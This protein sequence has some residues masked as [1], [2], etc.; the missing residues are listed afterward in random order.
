MDPV[1]QQIASF[2]PLPNRS[3][4]TDNYHASELNR[5][6]W[7]SLVFKLD[8]RPTENDAIG[9]RY[10]TRVNSSGSPYSGSDLGLFGSLANSLSTLAGVTYTRV[11]GPTLVNEARAGFVRMSDHEAS[12]YAG[13]DI[14]AQLGLPSITDDPHLVGFPRF[15]VLNLAAIGDSTGMPVDYTVNNYEIA[16]AVSWTRG[17]HLLK[18]GAD[19]LR[20]QF[21]QQLYNN[22]RGSFNFL[23][24]ASGVPF[25]DLL[26]GLPDSTSRQ[27][28]AEPAYLFS[29]DWGLFLQDHLAVTPRVTLDF[30][31]R[32]EMMRPPYEKQGRMSSFVPELNKVV[33]ADS[34]SIPDLPARLAAAGLTGRVITASQAGLPNSLVYANKLDLAPRFGLA[35]RPF[36]NSTLVVRAAY[37]IFYADSLLNPIRNDLTNAIRSPYRRPSIACQANRSH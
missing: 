14:N 27:S 28:S 33:I 9:F 7:N 22:S 1:A 35:V 34:Q 26:L 21:F 13:Q 2:Y 23:G 5:T 11:L 10:L 36:R 37:G 3:D 18:F 20:T 12:V 15:T 17:R 24:R 8:E 30:G 29:S 19:L 31:L 4:P 6:D 16:D 32:Y 25:A